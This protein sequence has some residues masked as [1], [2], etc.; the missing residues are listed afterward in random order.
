MKP[1]QKRQSCIC[2]CNHICSFVFSVLVSYLVSDIY[3][4]RAYVSIYILRA[5]FG[6]ND[7]NRETTEEEMFS[8]KEKSNWIPNQNSHTVDTFIAA[9]TND[10][11]QT[12]MSTQPKDNLTKDERKALHSLKERQDTKADKGEATKADK[13]E[14]TVIWD[15]NNY[16]DECKR[17]L[18]NYNF[19]RKLDH[20]PIQDHVDL[21]NNTLDEFKGNNEL[22]PE[23]LD[24]LKPLEPKTPR[25]Y[26]LP[27]IHKEENPGRPVV[28]SVNCHTSKISKFVDYHIQPLAN[29]LPSYVK[30]T[31]D[32]INK[33]KDI[34]PLPSNSY[35]VTMDVSSL[36]TNIPHNEGLHALREKLDLRQ[37]K[38]VSTK[39]LVTLIMRLILTLNNFI[40]NGINYLQIKGCA[41]RTNSSPS[42]ANI[43]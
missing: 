26:M 15:V 12:P 8:R 36:Y 17:Q 37:N 21:I 34:G 38:S 4:L 32:F 40:F 30:D 5:Y 16:V 18:N 6:I 14:A 27:K 29:E 42:F 11:S 3:I 41:M 24:G 20:N 2:D 23:I 35:L 10:I 19:Y 39:V 25:L 22:S 28:S 43:F 13:G 9:V 33:I 1:T 31:T 7:T